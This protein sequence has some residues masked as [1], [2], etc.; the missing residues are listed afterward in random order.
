MSDALFEDDQSLLPADWDVPPSILGRLG[1]TVGRQRVIHESGHV[2][3]IVHRVPGPE[4]DER[5]GCLSWREP[6][7]RWRSADGREGRVALRET[8]DE[9]ASTL[10][11]L[12]DRIERSPGIDEH[13]E[14]IEHLAPIARA[15]RHLH[16]T[17]QQARDACPSDRGV[18]DLRDLAYG[19]ERRAEL[20]MGDARFSLDR[21]LARSAHEQAQASRRGAEAADRLNRLAA[22]FLPLGTA[23]A[24]LGMNVQTGLETL[25]PP[26]PLVIILAAGLL[27]GMML[28]WRIH[29]EG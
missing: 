5:H 15:A 19:I 22:V 13:F 20:L 1:H 12:D 8:I 10:A 2:L 26:W 24:I 14:I 7:G 18:I 9:Y 6:G 4:E 3:V 28:S 16:E 25:P 11:R 17:L 23:A 29:R 21:G 27:T